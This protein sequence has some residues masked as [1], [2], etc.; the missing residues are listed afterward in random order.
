M[1]T[2]SIFE[3]FLA[4]EDAP[5]H[6]TR[7]RTPEVYFPLIDELSRQYRA[8]FRRAYWD[9]GKGHLLLLIANEKA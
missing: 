5:F 9:R 8:K 7:T 4:S 2:D 6:Y 1:D 3:K